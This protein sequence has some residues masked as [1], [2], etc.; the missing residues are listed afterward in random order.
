MESIWGMENIGKKGET[1]NDILQTI[2][3][4][5]GHEVYR[6]PHDDDYRFCPECGFRFNEYSSEDTDSGAFQATVR[7]NLTVQ[8][9][10]GSQG[11]ED[12]DIENDPNRLSE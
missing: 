3:P 6:K 5:C 2:C 1:M 4:E 9:D 8:R 11:A 10:L 12:G 7:Q